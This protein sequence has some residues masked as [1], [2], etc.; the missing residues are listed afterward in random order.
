MISNTFFS[1]T[2]SCQ[3]DFCISSLNQSFRASMDW[4]LICNTRDTPV[5]KTQ[6]LKA[7]FSTLGTVCTPGELI[8]SPTL[9]LITWMTHPIC[10]PS[11]LITSLIWSRGAAAG[12]TIPHL[13]QQGK[14][15]RD[16]LLP[17]GLRDQQ[18]HPV[19]I[20]DPTRPSFVGTRPWHNGR[21]CPMTWW[22]KQLRRWRAVALFPTAKDGARDHLIGAQCPTARALEDCYLLCNFKHRPR[23]PGGLLSFRYKQLAKS[24]WDIL[25]SQLLW[26]ATATA[27][28]SFGPL[29]GHLTPQLQQSQL[30]NAT[31]APSPVNVSLW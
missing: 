4:R 9:L 22:V 17:Q 30:H 23:C 28:P 21:R 16:L 2:I 10:F 3:S 25:P 15:W 27:P 20:P 8:P 19:P 24:E 11:F 7:A 6:E 13:T 29:Q 26:A 18:P 5:R 12:Q 31:H 1:S 14:N